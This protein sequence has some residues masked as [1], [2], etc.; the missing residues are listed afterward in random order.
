MDSSGVNLIARWQDINA[1]WFSMFVHVLCSGFMIS[2]C[3]FRGWIP[4]VFGSYVAESLLNL[5]PCGWVPAG[6]GSL[7]LDP[8]RIWVLCGWIPAGFWSCVAG[9]HGLVIVLM[10]GSLLD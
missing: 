4:A 7:W 8:N 2:L 6:F 5:G 10:A 9:S 1:D 3:G